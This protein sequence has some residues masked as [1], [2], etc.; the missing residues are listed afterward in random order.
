MHLWSKQGRT[1]TK[2]NKDNVFPQSRNMRIVASPQAQ[3]QTKRLLL[4]LRGGVDQ[5][6]APKRD[7]NRD[8][9]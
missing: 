6:G 2:T 4:L 8:N 5:T 7:N 3:A 1:N 9:F